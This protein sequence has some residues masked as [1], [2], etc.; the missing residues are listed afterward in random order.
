MVTALARKKRRRS[1]AGPSLL[2]IIEVS[3]AEQLAAIRAEWSELHQQCAN[4][5]P[6]LSWEWIAAMHAHM[7]RGPLSVLVAQRDGSTV[8]IV[9][10][11]RVTYR[12]FP[13]LG[14]PTFQMIGRG[15]PHCELPGLLA[16]PGYESEVAAIAVVYLQER[17]PRWYAAI[18]DGFLG[19]S[20]AHRRVAAR[21][22][23]R[24][25]LL[26]RPLE[27]VTHPMDLPESWEAFRAGLKRNIKESL[28]HCYN[29]LARDG[30]TYS[31]EVWDEP[32]RLPE[33]LDRFLLLHHSRSAYRGSD[34]RHSDYYASPNEERFLRA[35]SPELLRLGVLHP[36]F[37]R[38]DGEIVAS[39]LLL[40]CGGQLYLHHSGFD[41]RWWRYSV[42]TTLVAES[43]KWA[44]GRGL[45]VMNLSSGTDVSKTRWN[46]SRVRYQ[47]VIVL[48]KGWLP[49]VVLAVYGT[50]C[51]D[52]AR[53]ACDRLLSRAQGAWGRR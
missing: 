33:A 39:R 51:R 17:S 24:T 43:I 11:E 42:A 8:G 12:L 32:A 49:Q 1:R 22:G 18:L 25:D 36:A 20:A 31:F 3:T 46:V 26:G 52:R 15:S 48:A 2:T 13:G 41:P 38:V 21:V 35:L 7:P 30:H 45:R 34:A 37:L 50:V 10:F 4:T 44:I 5:N 40:E 9:P 47:S 19:G 27:R 53:R 23:D 28:R 29:S 6:F 14:L 16:L